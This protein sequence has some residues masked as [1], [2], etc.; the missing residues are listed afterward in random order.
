MNIAVFASGRGTNFA[1]IIRA[2]KKGKLAA[3]ISLLVCDNPKAG[4]IGKARRAGVEVFLIRRQDF[5]AK[6]DFEDRII[7][8]LEEAGIDLV[9]L[10]GFMRILSPEFV[11]RFKFKVLNIH[12][13]LLPS[14][15]GTQGIE[16]AFNC[17]VKVTGVTVHFVDE[18]MDH[19]PI[20]LQEAVKIK[21]DDTLESL[22]ARVHKVEHKIYPQAIRLF[23]ENRLKLEGRKVKIL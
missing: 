18:Q 12:P 11:G 16:D 8:R 1:A 14:F 15:K 17:G 3:N 4:A 13:A 21:E 7:Q 10:A 9:V 20:I 6:R 5:S 19:G 23:I 2:V 22:E